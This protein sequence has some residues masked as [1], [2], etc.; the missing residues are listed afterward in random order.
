MI[1]IGDSFTLTATVTPS[2]ATD[3]SITWSNSNSSVVS[4]SD[5]VVRALSEGTSTITVTT[6]DGGYKASCKV[7]V[8]NDITD[9]VYAR[10]SGGSIMQLG[11]LIQSGS[12]LNFSVVNNSNKKILVKSCQLIDGETGSKS[13][14]MGINAEIDANSSKGWS[15]TIGSGGIH[16]PICKFIFEYDNKEYE[17]SAAYENN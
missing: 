15:I 16:S 2:D 11:T 9:L 6:K 7:T 1:M 12:S 14:V 5:G 13:G 10:F 3:P 17:I 4:L 8:T